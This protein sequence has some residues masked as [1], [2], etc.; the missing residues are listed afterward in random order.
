MNRTTHPTTSRVIATRVLAAALAALLTTPAD[1]ARKRKQ[2]WRRPADAVEV[3]NCGFEDEKWDIN[4]DGWPDRWRRD[5]GPGYPHYVEME[6]AA[7]PETSSG[8][9]LRVQLDGAQARLSSPPIYI[10]PKYGYVLELKA[11]VENAE[12]SRVGV[13]IDYMNSAGE[14]RQTL[15]SA[16]LASDG[17]WVTLVLDPGRPK[18]KDIDRAVLHIETERGKQGDLL[19]EVSIAD[20][21]IGR[22]PSLSVSANNRFHVYTDPSDVEVTCA[23]SGIGERDPEIR[24]QLLDATSSELGRAGVERLD[25]TEIVDG[26]NEKL[27]HEESRRASDIV[28]GVGN[29]ATG[30]EG[31]TTWRPEIHRHGSFGFY[32]VRVKMLSSESGQLIDERTITLAVIPPPVAKVRGEFGWTLPTADEPLD[33]A[34]LESLLPLVGLN[35]VKLPIWFPANTPERGEAILQFA[36]RLSASDIETVGVIQHPDTLKPAGLAG[37]APLSRASYDVANV[38]GGNPNQWLPLY[39]HIMARLSLRVR[40]W[41]LGAD[42]DTS[43]VGYADLVQQISTIRKNLYRF[44]QDVG[45]G[46]GWRWDTP[47]LPEGISWEFQQ[48]AAEP[49]L[50]A[51]QLDEHLR[52]AGPHQGQRW[53]L[54]NTPVMHTPGAGPAQ[55][56]EEHIHRVQ[57]FI[58]QIVVAKKHGVD[59]IFINEPFSGPRGV[60]T[61]EGKPGEL[62]LPWRTTATLLGGAEYMGRLQL[63]SGS[64]NWLF[65]RADGNVVMVVWNDAAVAGPVNEALYLGDRVGLVDVWGKTAQ[66]RREGNRH[67]VPVHRVPSFVMGLNEAVARW[68]MAFRFEKDKLPSV[69]GQEH[70]NALQIR[71]TF[72]QGVGGKVALFVPDL[73]RSSADQR[74][75]P[76]EAWDIT[77]PGEDFNAPAGEAVRIPIE[78]E[79]TDAAIGDQPVRVDFDVYAD[80]VDESYRF[81]VWRSMHVGLGDIEIDI[82]TALNE[83]GLLMVT[84]QMRN[85]SG[86]PLSFKCFLQAPKRRRK[87]AQV[88]E[89]GPELDKKTYT[90]AAGENLLGEELKLRVEE[91]DGARVLIKRFVVERGTPP[92]AETE[93]AD[94]ATDGAT[95][96]T[97]T[98]G[99]R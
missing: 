13:K 80:R 27:I 85:T 89:L 77:L 59:G 84:Q 75:R 88:F 94:G 48:M 86:G 3:F 2:M 46:L 65:R 21:W 54:I 78:I 52:K 68:R 99:T 49:P 30:Y 34:T 18:Y 25:G 40:W 38:F 72:G 93:I 83:K 19:G 47:L 57:E 74:Q 35:W 81:S 76:S 17:K 56:K 91:I 92:G 22:R 14:V 70:P 58:K 10:L 67:V 26:R 20:I 37:E 50:D 36:E 39:E 32:Q 73:L 9:C 51:A 33:F 15:R 96:A 53:V 82:A 60:M 28:D 71:N 41:Q 31:E 90:Y 5:E 6:L 69:F 1:A 45:L 98:A 44:G 66:P 97:L 55:R 24:F 29:H 61:E 79:L 11:R 43:F 95:A 16:D 42:R 64:Q 63:P 8:R 4:Y 7:A 12:H 23:L 62:L 87:R